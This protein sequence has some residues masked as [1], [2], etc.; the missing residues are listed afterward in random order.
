MLF[1]YSIV[2]K[3]RRLRKASLCVS[4]LFCLTAPRKFLS[5]VLPISSISLLSARSS[6]RSNKSTKSSIL[7]ILE[8]DL[9]TKL[10]T[11]F[12]NMSSSAPSRN[13]SRLSPVERLRDWPVFL[14]PA[15]TR[16]ARLARLIAPGPIISIIASKRSS[17]SPKTSSAVM[18][19][20]P[21]LMRPSL[22]RSASEFSAIGFR[23]MLY[24]K[25]FAPLHTR[26]MNIAL[27]L[28]LC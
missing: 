6:N 23:Q 21:P 25:H 19:G 5:I 20:P 11:A 13:C 12:W 10:R 16:N 17:F 4:A 28:L 18:M 9:L 3:F 8:P 26:S 24:E 7:L 2:R 1:V 27:K 15:I 22:A 14:P